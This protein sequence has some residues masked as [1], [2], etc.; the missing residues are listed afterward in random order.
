MNSHENARL[1]AIG[2]LRL[3]RRMAQIGAEQAAAEA[4]ISLR[5]ARKWQKRFEIEGETGLRDRSSRPRKVRRTLTDEEERRALVWRE[6]RWTIRRI[7]F[8]L[9]RPYA[10]VRRFLAA[11]RLN[12]LPPLQQPPPVIRYERERPGEMLHLDTKKLGRIEKV[13]HRITGDPRDHTRGV[14]W[15]VLHLA[16]DDHSRLA[17]T[18]VLPDE[19]QDTA[20][21]FLMRALVWFGELGV[22]V[23]RV[24]TDNGS[25]YRSRP[26][27]SVLEQ[28][29]IRHIFTRPYTPRTN[30]KA[31]RF[32]Q[33]ALR[34]WAYAY[35]YQHSNERT[36]NLDCWQRFY[37]LHR[38][39]SA[40][41]YHSPITRIPGN[42]VSNL[43]T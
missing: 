12:R 28:R 33:T 6:Q 13:G 7:A 31:E 30:G 21:A 4:G 15:E 8:E 3:V 16:I 42:N 2:R 37:N 18:E 24:M 25:C 23:E 26:F 11:Q 32:V 43:N 22:T 9:A 20:A 36:F 17:Y 34:E 39:H 41:G 40:L 27:R 29:G 38:P 10:T 1:T 35:T 19:R 5:S 14:G